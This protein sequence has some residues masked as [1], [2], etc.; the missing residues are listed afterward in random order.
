M[1][2]FLALGGLILILLVLIGFSKLRAHYFFFLIPAP[3]AFFIWIRPELYNN[4]YKSRYSYIVLLAIILNGGGMVVKYFTEPIRCS[5]CQLLVPYTNIGVALK[6]IGFKKGTIFAYYHPHD[7]AGNFRRIFPESRI[8]S[9]KFPKLA[10]K[11]SK[12]SGQCLVVWTPKPQGR[13]NGI[14]MGQML[15]KHLQGTFPINE[16][17]KN[18]DKVPQKF[19]KYIFDRSKNKSGIL[20]YMLLENGIGKC[21]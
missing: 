13:M 17:Y 10:S 5:L 14:G 4:V 19:Q 1:N 16:W 15:N 18:H 8:V 11:A 9:T 7:L 12:N 2:Y 3:L 20:G 6:N 21:R